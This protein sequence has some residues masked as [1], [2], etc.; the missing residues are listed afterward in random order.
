MRAVVFD[1]FGPPEVLQLR[2]I[3]APT[4]E[5]GEVLIRVHA[6]SVTKFDCWVRS[7]TAPP[8]F[9]LLLK[10]VSG[11]KPKQP[12]LGTELSGEVAALG[13]GV[14][15]FNIGEAVCGY[16]TR[17]LGSY[18]EYIRLPRAA[19]VAKPTNLSFEQAAVIFQGGLTALYFLRLAR[20]QPG[21][22]VLVFGASGGV[23]SYAIQLARRHFGAHVTGVCSGSKMDYVRSL[24]ADEVMDYARDDFPRKDVLYD[25]IFDTVGRTAIARARR[26]L[27]PE[28][29]YLLATFSLAM[30]GQMLWYGRFSRQNYKFGVLKE[31]NEDLLEMRNLVEAGTILP[32]IDRIFP[33]EAAAE[34]Q[35]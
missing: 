19:V 11:R 27:A 18:A 4:P 22:K 31:T 5:P 21:Q 25:V 3:A 2:E 34:A 32:V 33:L 26:V 20:I 7:N 17:N 23:G 13:E 14:T 29:T 15:G 9:D 12:I 35:R 6:A 30:L 24:G 1:S 10:L 8:G 28:G 16:T